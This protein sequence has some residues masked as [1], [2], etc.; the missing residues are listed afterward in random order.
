MRLGRLDRRELDAESQKDIE[1]AFAACDRCEGVLQSMVG[2]QLDPTKMRLQA[3]DLLALV[4][5]VTLSWEAE[6]S[7]VDLVVDS[8][9]DHLCHLPEV[10]FAQVLLDLLDN[11]EEAMAAPQPGDLQLVIACDEDVCRVLVR[12]R[13]PGFPE[14]VRNNLGQPFLT[15]K[16]GGNGLGLY[17]A[18]SLAVALGGDLHLRGR[19]GGGAEIALVLPCNH[20]LSGDTP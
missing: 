18:H 5:R 6:H 20:S 15:T 9:P 11:A 2:R 14:V 10:P 13:G 19:D 4:R 7:S 12:D 8:A 17:N 3:T 1:A 16:A